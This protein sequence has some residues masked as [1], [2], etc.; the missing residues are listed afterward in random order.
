MAVVSVGLGIISSFVYLSHNRYLAAGAMGLAAVGY[1]AINGPLFAAIQTLVPERMRAMSIALLFLFANLIGVGLGPL[2]VDVLSDALQPWAGKLSLRYV[3]PGL[4]SGYGWVA[5][6]F[7][8]CSR[9]V[10][11]DILKMEAVSGSQRKIVHLGRSLLT[12]A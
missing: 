1:T 12:A 2:T 7:W 9:T 8:R 5:W 4:C 6:H 11:R 3:L 10:T